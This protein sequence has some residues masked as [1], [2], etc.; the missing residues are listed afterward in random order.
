M[1]ITSVLDFLAEV[2]V[3]LQAVHMRRNKATNIWGRVFW[4][5]LSTTTAEIIPIMLVVHPI[6]GPQMD[7]LSFLG[8]LVRMVR[9]LRDFNLLVIS[10]GC[11]VWVAMGS[12]C[13]KWFVRVR[14]VRN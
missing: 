6:I 13:R 14:Y 5:N 9:M 12:K 7:L 3:L 4:Q 8:F 10:A 11:V 1:H 2:E